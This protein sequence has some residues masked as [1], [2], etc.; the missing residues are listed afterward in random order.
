MTEGPSFVEWKSPYRR[1]DAALYDVDAVTPTS[2]SVTYDD[3]QA[4]FRAIEAQPYRPT[5]YVVSPTEGAWIRNPVGQAPS[6]F[7]VD[8][9]LA[10]GAITS[11]H[12]EV[13]R[14]ARLLFGEPGALPPAE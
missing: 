13:K 8:V 7:A 2:G 1:T 6:L 9:A 4:A 3:L 10:V 11:D 12:P 14:Y 5:Q